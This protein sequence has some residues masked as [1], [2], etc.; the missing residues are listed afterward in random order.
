L[1][2]GQGG[3]KETERIDKGKG[4]NQATRTPAARTTKEREKKG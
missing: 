1:G 4:H 3:K 2:R